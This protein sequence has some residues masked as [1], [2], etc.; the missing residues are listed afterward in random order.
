MHRIPAL[1]SALI[2]S[3]T[4]ALKAN[5]QIPNF[6]RMYRIIALE[7]MNNYL[8]IY[9]Y[10]GS[11]GNAKVFFQFQTKRDIITH[12]L[13]LTQIHIE[14][15]TI[16]EKILKEDYC[17]QIRH[18]PTGILH[19]W[20]VFPTDVTWSLAPQPLRNAYRVFTYQSQLWRG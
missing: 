15:F 6:Q 16:E 14:N 20:T 9:T 13:L 12:C 4:F 18:E 3:H 11:V 10:L 1:F 17:V 2:P 8:Q 5:K 7:G 19:E